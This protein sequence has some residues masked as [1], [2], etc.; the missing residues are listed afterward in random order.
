MARANPQVEALE[1]EI[2]MLR[3]QLTERGRD[4][5]DNPV[6][7]CGDSSC[8]VVSQAGKGGQHTN[9]VC[10]CEPLQ[11]RR[12]LAYWKRRGEFLQETIRIMRDEPERSDAD[13]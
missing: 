8:M 6:S 12:A 9:G 3:R 2:A 4:P 1:R 5:G 7:G 10:R 13:G 11:F